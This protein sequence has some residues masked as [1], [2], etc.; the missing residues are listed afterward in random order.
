MTLMNTNLKKSNFNIFSWY[1]LAFI[2]FTTSMS[3]QEIDLKPLGSYRDGSFDEAAAEIVKYDP[4]TKR[5]FSVNGDKNT[6]DIIDISD[7][8]APS[9]YS[10]IDLEPFGGGPNSVDVSRGK[11]AVAVE[12]EESTDLGKVVI[13]DTDGKF[14]KEFP[15]GA[16]PDGLSF[17]PNGRL[18]VV[19]NEGEPNDE[20]T[21]DPEGSITI[22]DL[23]RNRVKQLGF[24]R[25]N[26]FKEQLMAKGIR[27]F[28]PNASVAQDLEPEFVTISDDNQ[29]AFITLQEN[30]AVA[31]VDLSRAKII[32]LIPLGEKDHS[33]PGNGLDASNRDDAINITNWPVHGLY[34]P[35]GITNFRVGKQRYLITANEG[36][37][38]DYDGFS[39]EERVEDIDLDPQFFPDA[40]TLQDEANLGRLNIT[41]SM[42]SVDGVFQK[43]YSYGTRSFS[44]WNA[45]TGELVFDS[46]DQLEQIT[47]KL[48]PQY[49]NS[50]NDDNDSFDA[51]SDDKGPEP[52]AVEVARIGSRLLAFIGLERIGGI[53]IYEISNP[54]KPKFLNYVN[55]R[56]FDAD[57]DTPEALDLGVE[58]L[59]FIPAY[60][61]PN[62]K[63][64]LVSGNEVSGTVTVFQITGGTKRPPANQKKFALYPV[65]LQNQLY[66]DFGCKMTGKVSI[67]MAHAFSG[68]VK[69]AEEYTISDEEKLQLD[70]SGLAKGAYVLKA[71]LPDGQEIRK[72]VV[73]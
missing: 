18:V 9:L 41:T 71:K 12:A 56:N 32:K 26:P 16:L 48:V 6:I 38:R 15:A 69:I 35:D 53:M 3:A 73:K 67:K 13:F 25:F 8:T 31:V 4:K 40:E 24:K 65:P 7:P 55:N 46:G 61:S 68:K 50:N 5:L 64:L 49:F 47:A 44:I 28:G 11:V 70:V 10:Q 58:S 66:V 1:L 2:V 62:R 14:L 19:A 59:T 52:E 33:L 17:S 36:D 37:S 27:I 42:G 45:T 63:P 60:K 51:R 29:K 72:I 21:V 57:A 30:N 22:I 34:M 39:E 23:A 20:Y 43:L 54:S